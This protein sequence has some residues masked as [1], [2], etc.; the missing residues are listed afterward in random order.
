[1]IPALIN[2]PHYNTGLVMGPALTPI[3][4]FT[5]NFIIHNNNK[6]KLTNI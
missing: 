2:P 3:G 1:M 6:V 5:F 4:L